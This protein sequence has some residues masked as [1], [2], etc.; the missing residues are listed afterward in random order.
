MTDEVQSEVHRVLTNN[1]VEH[2]KAYHESIRKEVMDV[3]NDLRGVI[4]QKY[5]EL[6]ESCDKV[7]GMEKVCR[8]IQKQ[9][10]KAAEK[11]SSQCHALSK[12]PS[13]GSNN[14]NGEVDAL[15]AFHWL[16]QV[17]CARVL[18]DHCR[19]SEAAHVYQSVLSKLHDYKSKELP[20]FSKAARS[21]LDKAHRAAEQL[22]PLLR[23]AMKQQIIAL[24]TLTQGSPTLLDQYADLHQCIEVADGVSSVFALETFCSIHQ[25]CVTEIAPTTVGCDVGAAVQFLTMYLNFMKYVSSLS[26]HDG[27]TSLSLH[28][29]APM[30]I[31]QMMQLDTKSANYLDVVNV[32]LSLWSL[33]GGGSSQPRIDPWA[34]SPPSSRKVNISPSLLEGLQ[35]SVEQHLRTVVFPAAGTTSVS[36]VADMERALLDLLK[37]STQNEVLVAGY[38]H[39]AL[40]QCIQ[41]A[42]DN[43]VQK[44]VEEQ[45]S[46]LASMIQSELCTKKDP[47]RVVVPS[48]KDSDVVHFILRQDKTSMTKKSPGPIFNRSQLGGGAMVQLDT[49]LDCTTTSCRLL[50]VRSAATDTASV[51]V[52]I[53]SRYAALMPPIQDSIEQDCKMTKVPHDHL[54]FL[55]AGLSKLSDAVLL[56]FSETV[57]PST[58]TPLPL[59]AG[60]KKLLSQIEDVYLRCHNPWMVEYADMFRDS[61]HR[62]WSSIRGMSSL[63]F[64]CE[65]ACHGWGSQK[66]DVVTVTFP[67]V[68][69]PILVQDL[70]SLQ[71]TVY[72]RH[73]ETFSLAC[74]EKLHTM[75]LSSCLQELKELSRGTVGC[76]DGRM[77]IVFDTLFLLGMKRTATE[78]PRLVHDILREILYQIE[79]VDVVVWSVAA[80]WLM[81]SAQYFVSGSRLL[82]GTFGVHDKNLNFNALFSLLTRQ[83]SIEALP[84]DTVHHWKEFIGRSATSNN[85]VARFNL[86]PIITPVKASTVSIPSSA[87]QRPGSGAEESVGGVSLK[88]IRSVLSW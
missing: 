47:V 37:N 9:R 55:S 17:Y 12:V 46:H 40:R 81:Y 2:V 88:S 42:A 87:E 70:F 27:C 35:Q 78:V 86:L 52:G 59:P 62:S 31:E 33:A 67:V 69:S 29:A 83:L 3:Q 80:P 11:S 19:F 61:L 49:L 14:N 65:I 77:Q 25:E 10:K 36:C 30:G 8:A 76:D 44:L 13:S 32:Q 72:V 53:V 15:T 63:V 23:T 84:E 43:A 1:T 28:S 34:M 16:D 71:S 50:L 22:H 39:Q 58:T 73:P 41:A 20:L 68:P 79:R 21:S 85:E 4:G 57:S 64:A 38:S 74:A 48:C 82:L 6:L 66:V 51:I 5:R 24:R 54:L 56:V 26:V 7:V 75:C 45:F 60:V 18:L